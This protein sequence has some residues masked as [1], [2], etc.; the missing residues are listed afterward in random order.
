MCTVYYTHFHSHFFLKSGLSS[1]LM[2]IN[3]TKLGTSWISADK[4][5]Q[6]REIKRKKNDD[7][8]EKMH[9]FR[10]CKKSMKRA[11][12]AEERNDMLE[13]IHFFCSDFLIWCSYWTLNFVWSRDGGGGGD[14]YRAIRLWCFSCLADIV[15]V[16][17]I[18]F[19]V[20]SIEMILE[21]SFVPLIGEGRKSEDRIEVEKR[22]RIVVKQSD[23]W[24]KKN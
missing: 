7:S 15:A 3:K 12:N 22:K 20:D 1:L 24:V 10:D 14:Y 16:A 19:F 23:K 5:Y 17:S 8:V 4:Y 9:R 6:A 18:G 2:W 11:N 21:V 13:R